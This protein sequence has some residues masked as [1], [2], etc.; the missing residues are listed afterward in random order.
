[1]EAS[2]LSKSPIRE[3]A[4]RHGH[5]SYLD[6]LLRPTSSKGEVKLNEKTSKKQQKD[7]EYEASKRNESLEEIA[8]STPDDHYAKKHPGAG[9]AGYKHPRFGGY[10]DALSSSS[11][12][13]RT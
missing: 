7:Q 8:A 12:I 11:T 4:P 10:L 13:D 9:W 5:N 2:G 1:M 3:M 6:S